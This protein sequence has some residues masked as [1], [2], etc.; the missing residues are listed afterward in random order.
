VSPFSRAIAAVIVWCLRRPKLVVFATSVVAILGMWAASRLV[1]DAIPDL[2]DVQVIIRTPYPG[3]APQTVEDQVTYPIS[4]ALLATPRSTAVRGYSLF[5]VSFV[6][7]VFEPGVDAYW[8]RTRVSERLGQLAGGLPAE[9]RPTLG[10]DAS[11]V[12]WIYEYALVDRH[13]RLDL[14][15]IRAVQDYFLR[16]ELQSVPGVAEVATVGGVTR[17]Y[18]V[19]VD[20]L[21]LAA[22][23]IGFEQVSRA[24]RQSS[25]DGSGGAVALG[26]AE[27]MIRVRGA[28]RQASELEDIPVGLDANRVPVRLKDVA[29]IVAGPAMR[30][31]VADLNG[32]GEVCGGIV[33]ARYGEDAWTVCNRVK[34]KLETLAGGLPKGLEVVPIYDRSNVIAEAVKALRGKLT[35]ESVAVVIVCVAF[36]LHLRSGLVVLLTLPVSILAAL[37]LLRIQGVS[38]NIMSLGG[39]AIAVGAMVDASIV[40]IENMHKKLERAGPERDYW[41]IARVSAIEVGPGLFSSLLITT[42]SFLPIF[43]LSG[44]EGKL[45][46]PLALTKTY[47]MAAGAILGVTVT[48][49]LMAWLVRG[50]IV[51]EM[52]NPLN[53]VIEW[54][55]RPVLLASLERPLVTVGVAALVTFSAVWPLTKTG[56]EYMPP[57]YEGDLLY[58]PT[59]R[60]GISVSEAARLAQRTDWMIRAFPEVESVLGKAGAAD[61]VTDPAPL[62]MLE[63]TI[64]LKPRNEWP[65]GETVEQLIAKLDAAVRLPGLVNSW[66]APIRTRLDMLSTGVKSPVGVRVSGHD[67]G[68]L[69]ALADRIADVLRS[70]QGT[71]SVFADV[72]EGGRFVDI[73]PDRVLAAQYGLTSGEIVQMTNDAIGG[74]SNAYL[75]EGRNRYPISVRYPSEFRDSPEAIA[76]MRLMSPSGALVPL[77]SVADV[78]IA[79]GP[80]EVRSENGRL[81]ILIY[82]DL[83]TP[84]LSGYVRRAQA[85]VREQAPVSSGSA[86]EWTGQYEH[87]ERAR[88]RLLWAVPLT[89]GAVVAL[90][91][92]QTNRVEQVLMVLTCLPISLAGGLWCV[93]LLG[94]QFSVAVAA[95]FIALAGLSVEFGIVMLIYLELAVKEA[96]ATGSLSFAALRTAILHGTLA[97]LRPKHMTLA[98]IFAGL[99]PMFTS[100]GIGLDVMRRIAA[101]MVGGMVTAPLLSLFLMPVLFEW[102][103][104]RTVPR[105]AGE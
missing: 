40:L 25:G 34:G 103:A 4:S 84:D 20:P 37:A 14:H 6:Y 22:R 67:P 65:R 1:L 44:P 13:H 68:E 87:L 79:E 39:I 41:Q 92:L 90:L 49:V 104:G 45:F 36:L 51:P 93:Y 29:R 30:R 55:Y 81:S 66:G 33:V 56:A 83:S 80:M 63:T 99:L 16:Y 46:T 58:M 74:H 100:E 78:G 26:G 38:A 101:P 12:G 27:Y 8:A 102:R 5:G 19:E 28:L 50:R 42:V 59:T 2:S 76:Q 89:V 97:R 71:R 61:T 73:Q 62:S 70:V 85:A 64:R 9:A 75:I 21:E 60:P 11:G 91:Y 69:K 24:V 96:E 10:P 105:S 15:E 54:I 32:E 94:Y 57:L 86:V 35:E 82:V 88:K 48:P 43:V 77:S 23:E 98:V 47:A 72:P 7:V 52:R 17:E 3:Q 31:G 18:R 95:G 53:R